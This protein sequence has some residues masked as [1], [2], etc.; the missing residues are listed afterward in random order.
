MR[1]HPGLF[2][3]QVAI[4]MAG[5]IPAFAEKFQ[6]PQFLPSKT[7]YYGILAG[8]LTGSGRQDLVYWPLGAYEVLRN[9]G[10]R[11]FTDL[12]PVAAPTALNGDGALADFNGDGKLDLVLLAPE[13]NTVSFYAGNGDGTFAAP[14]VSPA[15]I[16]IAEAYGTVLFAGHMNTAGRLDLVLSL[17]FGNGIQILNGDGTGRFSA[18]VNFPQQAQTLEEVRDING[19][20]LDDL[21][22]FNYE[23]S[24]KV[25]TYRN[26]GSGKFDLITSF[27]VPYFA[28]DSRLIRSV[29]FADLKG[30]GVL[31]IICSTG[32]Y[33]HIGAASGNSKFTQASDFVFRTDGWVMAAEDINGDGSPDLVFREEQGAAVLLNDGNYT[34]HV[35]NEALSGEAALPMQVTDLDGDGIPDVLAPIAAPDNTPGFS[36]LWGEPGGLLDSAVGYRAPYLLSGMAT[37]NFTLGAAPDFSVQPWEAPQPLTFQNQ[38]DGSFKLLP[39]P[40]SG[41]PLLDQ[42]PMFTYNYS[43]LAGDFNGDGKP[44]LLQYGYMTTYVNGDGTNTYL[45]QTLAGNGAGGFGQPQSISTTAYATDAPVA[46]AAGDLNGDG[47]QD[48]ASIYNGGISILLGQKGG[49]WVQSQNILNSAYTNYLIC[50][51]GDWNGDGIRDLAVLNGSEVQIFLG[52]GDG[53][54][55]AGQV[56]TISLPAGAS[57]ISG[58]AAD[59]DGDGKIDLLYTDYTGQYPVYG[60]GGGGFTVGAAIPTPGT[61]PPLLLATQVADVNRDGWPDLVIQTSGGGIIVR[62]GLGNRSWDP[63]AAYVTGGSSNLNAFWV[64]DLNQDGFPDI[65]LLDAG[66]G[67]SQIVAV[68]LNEPDL[69]DLSG[70]LKVNSEP[71]AQGATATATLTVQSGVSGQPAPTG[72]VQFTIDGIAAGSGNLVSGAVEVSL[73]GADKLLP[74]IHQVA[75]SY[76]GDSIYHSARF[77]E[78]HR[79]LSPA[80]IA[81]TT[82]LTAL[83]ASVTVGASVT[84]TATVTPASGAT[85]TGTVTFLNG[86][87][88][89]GSAALNA[90]G[91]ATLTLTPAVGSYSITASY[92]GSGTDAPSVSSAVPVTVSPLVNSPNIYTFA[93][94]GV[95]GYEGN[96]G[97]AVYAELD[98]PTMVATD[99]SGNVYIADVLNNVV[100]KVDAATGVITTVAG[101]GTPGFSGDG[102]LATMAELSGPFGIAL[103]AAGDLFIAD[104]GN[105]RVRKVN[106]TTGIIEAVA[107]DGLPGD[108]GNGGPAL[109]AAINPFSVA[110]D[111]SKNIYIADLGNN[112]LWKVTAK[113]GIINK[114]AGNGTKGYSGDGGPAIDA[115]L[116]DPLGVGLDSAGNI[117]F[118][119]ALNERVRKIDA[120]TGII[121]TVAGNGTYGYSGDGGPATSAELEQ[122][123]DVKVDKDGNLFIADFYNCVVRKVDA[124]TQVISTYAGDGLSGV[125]GD[126]GPANLA[127]LT[128]PGGVAL[129]ALENLYIATPNSERVRVVGAPPKTVTTQIA[130]TTLLQASATALTIGQSLMLT[131][132]VTPASGATPTGTVTFLNGATSLGSAALN[133]SGVATLTLTPA[134][135][136]YSITAN[137]GGSATDSPSTSAAVTVAVSAATSALGDWTWM[138]GGSTVGSNGQTA[139]VYGILGTPAVGNIPSGRSGEVSWTD[140]NGN[141]WLFGG[142]GSDASGNTGDLN[143]LWEFNPSSNVW[144]WMGGSSAAASTGVFGTLGVAAIGNIPSS[145]QFAMSWTDLSGN[146]WLYGGDGWDAQ[147]TYGGLGDLWKFNPSTNLWAWMGGNA[148]IPSGGT[149]YP[150]VYGTLG[151]PAAGNFPGGRDSAATWTD[152]SGNLWL[153]GGLG[154]YPSGV[155]GLFNDLWEF[156]PS[157]NEWAWMGGSNTAGSDC[158]A[159]GNY[160]LHPGVYGTLGAPASGNNPGSRDY[161]ATWTD[162]SGHLWLF[163]GLVPGTNFLS[164]LWEY[165]P[166]THEWAWMGGVSASNQGGVYGTLG[167]P[168]V[169]NI[170]GSRCCTLTRTDN[171]GNF[172]LFGGLGYDGNGNQNDLN[173]LWEYS[174]STNEW[175]WMG[176]DKVGNQSGIYGTLGTPAAA[177]LPG[178]R[179][180]AVSWVDGSGNF[181]VFGGTG[182]DGNGNTGNMNDLWRYGPAGGSK[183]ATATPFFAPP[184]GSYTGPQ[185]VEIADAT[186]GATIY[187]T[188]DGTTPTANSRVYSGPITISTT[189]TLKA[190]ATASGYSA[191]AVASATYTINKIA[192]STALSASASA[193]AFGQ[194]LTLTATVTAASGATPTGTVNFLNGATSLGSAALNAS[195]V[196]TLTLT[197]AVGSYSVTAAYGGSATDLPSTSSPAVAVTVAPA[198]TTTTLSAAPNPAAFGATVTFSAT[199]SSKTAIPAGSISFFDGKTLLGTAELQGGAASYATGALSAGSH[200][201]TAVYIP[202]A[203]FAASISNTVVEVINAADFSIAA[204]PAAQTVYTGEA[205]GYTVTIT[206]GSGFNL[207]VALSCSQLPANTSCAFTPSTVSGGNGSSTL[208]VQTTA[209][210]QSAKASGFTKGIGA[211]AL[212]GLL[213]LFLPLR[214]RK[215]PL[216]LFALVAVGIATG[217]SGCG[218][219]GSLH[220]GTPVGQQTVSITAIASNGAQAITHH[221]QVTLNVKSLF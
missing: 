84:L 217:M 20:G 155:E 138:D 143:D 104:S 124:A 56:L 113:T 214:F 142:A 169:G 193:V 211:T 164:D 105:S 47:I 185:S 128:A 186:P 194:P 153:Y 9:D 134:V 58:T 159:P 95:T 110:V 115:S 109:K 1:R 15:D 135:G 116:N 220:G 210:S 188:A 158:P 48:I 35:L 64:Q 57:I 148:T 44:D 5:V 71:Q 17:G 111:G 22:L 201:V 59:I 133:A 168:A 4:L 146:F 83:P 60:N 213:L 88:S 151:T 37:G 97:L 147:G 197:P 200:T 145:R 43:L 96:G 79:V 120:A 65:V 52:K 218:G 181:W 61:N 36:I 6:N 62:H 28:G 166:S 67:L 172:W 157:T 136:G 14:I 154:Y 33:I 41:P 25:Q 140:S 126:G 18:G 137:Y 114:I 81:T 2:L 179:Q 86:A 141:F 51:F 31:D 68:L 122:P 69:S 178:S 26:Q 91:V 45:I 85:P 182:Y 195:G 70:V 10:N 13:A 7:G 76:P 206:P 98:A 42:S 205:A 107:G 139:G 40:N 173:D 23:A 72:T 63:G 167:A 99:S 215:H 190:I 24:E 16:P 175:T 121:T 176:G 161:G 132:T 89:L 74:G 94:D 123:Q 152:S 144:V 53:T 170:P 191:S 12:G 184:A 203:G 55:T 90:S 108:S 221:A 100:R 87:T 106:G 27:T 101:N 189:E 29:Q 187:Y 82:I 125:S 39:D 66:P 171:S 46:V 150:P 30:D 162:E 216:M 34:F 118:G 73:A 93:G 207:D 156:N 112:C 196:A 177:N 21:V 127:Q 204:A 8:D 219:S 102:G 160:C 50:L 129:D 180:V 77:T 19:D 92:V 212:A 80:K 183:P 174:L 119:D 38:G 199:V 117:Y 209:P 198:A 202:A 192:T 131:T 163:G 49:G 149:S 54:F 130:T 3:L 208:V 78:S 75:A 165:F 103:D 32:F 11:Q